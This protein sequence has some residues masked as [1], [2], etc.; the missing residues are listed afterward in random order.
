MSLL[1]KSVPASRWRGLVPCLDL[2]YLGQPE[3]QNLGMAALADKDVGG[4]DVAVD[5]ALGVGGVERVRDLDRERQERFNFQRTPRDA[6]LQRQPVQKLHNDEGLPILLDNV[7][8]RADVG[9]VQCGRGLG[10]ALK[11]G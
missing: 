6:V 8:N 1:V 3:I 2:V 7:V 5:D 10:F 11:A 4:F 9:V